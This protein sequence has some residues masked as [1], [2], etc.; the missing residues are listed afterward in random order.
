MDHVY[1]DYGTYNI[2]F[3]VT[4]NDGGVVCATVAVLVIN[5]DPEPTLD[6]GDA[7]TFLGGD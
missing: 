6:T 5:L 7:A 3:T 2:E 1:G 4:D